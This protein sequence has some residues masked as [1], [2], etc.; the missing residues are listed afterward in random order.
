MRVHGDVDRVRLFTSFVRFLHIKNLLWRAIES[1]EM[2]Q[3]ARIVVA[4]A[5]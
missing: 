4:L 2:D 3:N 5:V 1:R